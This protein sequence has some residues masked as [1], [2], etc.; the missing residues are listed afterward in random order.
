MFLREDLKVNDEAHEKIV[1]FVQ[2][3]PLGLSVNLEECVIIVIAVDAT[4]SRPQ[5]HTHLGIAVVDVHVDVV[6]E[7]LALV[8]GTVAHAEV[9]A[10]VV[11]LRRAVPGELRLQP[12]DDAVHDA[13]EGVGPRVRL[14]GDLSSN[15]I[16]V[17]DGARRVRAVVE[18]HREDDALG[19]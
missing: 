14:E 13:G 5:L 1:I 3:C 15:G 17:M 8:N 12:S 19:A 2:E 4:K 11:I 16:A 9:Q 7:V 18:V 10:G 6:D